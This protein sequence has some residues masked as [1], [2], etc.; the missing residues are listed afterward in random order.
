MGLAVLSG[1]GFRVG[2]S[3]VLLT[4]LVQGAVAGL[5]AA[6]SAL[7]G[8]Q[9]VRLFVHGTSFGIPDPQ[10]HRDVS[11]YVFELCFTG[12]FRAG[13][14]PRWCSVFSAR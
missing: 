3:T 2:V 6:A 11:F 14:S 13:F 4:R 8:W 12:K 5:I 9:S 1:G 7:G 10:F